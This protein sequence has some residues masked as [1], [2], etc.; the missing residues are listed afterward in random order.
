VVLGD[1]SVVRATRD[2]EYSDLYGALPWSH[3]SLGFLVGLELQI[4]PVKVIS[5]FISVMS[6]AAII[7][8]RIPCISIALYSH[9]VYSSQGTKGLL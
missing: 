3:G 1:G 5:I 2:N 9:Y 4:V 7:T 6:S 8:H